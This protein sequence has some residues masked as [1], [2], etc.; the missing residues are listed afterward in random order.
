[1]IKKLINHRSERPS[2]VFAESLRFR[3]EV[4]HCWQG[5]HYQAPSWFP[6]VPSSTRSKLRDIPGE[7]WGVRWEGEELPRMKLTVLQSCK[8]LL[9]SRFTGFKVFIFNFGL[10]HVSKNILKTGMLLHRQP[11]PRRLVGYMEEP[12]HFSKFVVKLLEL[13]YL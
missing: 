12:M 10:S 9:Y 11:K 5:R 2:R 3:L 7:G 8:S 6:L 13:T 4:E 1:M